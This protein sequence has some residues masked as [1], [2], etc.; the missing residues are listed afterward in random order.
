MQKEHFIIIGL[1]IGIA[2]GGIGG[3]SL[4]SC[5][6]PEITSCPVAKGLSEDEVGNKVS[7]YINKKFLHPQGME[8]KITTISPYGENLYK[9]D[10]EI[11]MGTQVLGKE[12]VYATKDGELLVLSAK[13]LVNMSEKAPRVNVSID[14]D[15]SKGNKNAK[16][17]IIEFS[18]YACPYCAK[19][20]LQILPMIMEEYGNEVLFVFRD[21]PVHGGNSLKAAEAANCAGEQGKFWEYHELLFEKQNEWYSNL[22]MLETYASELGLDIAKFNKCLNSRKYEEE[23]LKDRQDGIKAGVTGTPTIFINGRIIEG[24]QPY[25]V[26]KEVIDDELE[27]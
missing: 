1:V 15:P 18:D 17:V 4:K 6:T 21:F 9:L 27:K 24:A 23:V 10:L 25:E 3:Y 20:E 26:F 11:L 12:V 5:K 13:C 7:T 16:V 14:D 2:I 8:G 22:S 19:F